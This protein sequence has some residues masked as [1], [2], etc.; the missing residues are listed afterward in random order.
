MFVTTPRLSPPLREM[1]SAPPPAGVVG[2]GPA[3][4]MN[5][6]P[7][8]DVAGTAILTDPNGKMIKL[9]PV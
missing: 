4:T 7:L 3:K 6:C 8:T 1:F 2:R 5:R 9:D